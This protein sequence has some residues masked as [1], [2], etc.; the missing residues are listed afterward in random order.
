MNGAFDLHDSMSLPSTIDMLLQIGEE[1]TFNFFESMYPMY[2]RIEAENGFAAA[3]Q[4]WKIPKVQTRL[5][6]VMIDFL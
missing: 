3:F 6:G 2:R 4:F 1:R 5:D